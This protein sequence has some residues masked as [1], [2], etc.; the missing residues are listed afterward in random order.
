MA[1]LLCAIVCVLSFLLHLIQWS[2][3]TTLEECRFS[4]VR[5][6]AMNP[7]THSR[8]H[9]HMCNEYRLWRLSYP[10][11][12]SLSLCRRLFLSY[13]NNDSIQLLDGGID[14]GFHHVEVRC[15]CLRACSRADCGTHSH[16]SLARL[17]RL[18]HFYILLL[19]SLRA[20]NRA[21]CTLRDVAAKL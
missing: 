19:R 20:I 9:T 15:H 16:F 8:R 21:C 4:T 5:F 18:L 17:L 3:T 1:P 6:K 2:W 12:L 13:F 7:S 14:S 10:C 11:T